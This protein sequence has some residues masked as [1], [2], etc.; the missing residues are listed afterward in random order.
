MLVAVCVARAFNGMTGFIIG[1]GCSI[2][3]K[4]SCKRGA[5][6][7]TKAI[8][9]YLD[10][11]EGFLHSSDYKL[12]DPNNHGCGGCLLKKNLSRKKGEKCG[13]R[14][15]AKLELIY[16]CISTLQITKAVEAL[17]AHSKS[18]KNANGLLL[19]ENENFFLMV[20]L[21]KIPSKELRVRL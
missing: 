7:Q 3:H 15:S 10:G 19:N 16:L 9:G 8:S 5:F 13:E 14:A 21:W 18:R 12:Q 6:L 4:V 1:R 20:V 17:L 11:S 2:W